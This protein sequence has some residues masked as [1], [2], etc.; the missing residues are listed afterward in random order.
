MKIALIQLRPTED[1]A[2]SLR[3]GLDALEEAAAAGA[4]L[5]VY[6]ELAFTPFFPQHRGGPEARSLAEPVPGPTTALFQEAARRLGV[7][8]VIN[9]YER[10]GDRAFDTSPVIDADGA[11]LG[12]TRM[13]HITQYEGFYEQDYYDPGDTGAPVYDTAAGRLGVAICYDRHYP[14][15]LRA[16][17]LGGADLVVVPQA[18]ATGEWPEGIYEAELQVPAFQ[19]GCF[20][21][22]AN[23]VGA[24]ET[25]TFAG[26]SFVVDPKGQ[27]LAQAPFGEEAILYADLDLSLCREAPARQLFLRHRRPDQYEGGAVRL[28]G[29]VTA[30]E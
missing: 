10:D 4:D 6:P 26:G 9:L 15:Y 27:V 21:A 24:E 7:V 29:A 30:R 22:L 23:R 2:R 12:R 3:R 28:A 18:G 25:L 13:M 20:M 8:V 14:E 1:H 16:L 19:N 5:V 17:A 11:L